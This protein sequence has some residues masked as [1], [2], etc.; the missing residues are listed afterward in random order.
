LRR[1]RE[2]AGID[3]H[4]V[5]AAELVGRERGLVLAAQ[6]HRR[7]GGDATER[8]ALRVDQEPLRSRRFDGR[9]LHLAAVATFLVVFLAAGA[10]ALAGADPAS[11]SIRS[12]SSAPS[13]LRAPAGFIDV[14]PDV[15]LAKR[16]RSISKSFLL[17]F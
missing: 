11:R 1:D 2:L 17:A 5:I 13:P 10:S 12:T 14:N 9:G 4:D 8:L 7:L 3:D 6:H 16:V 15:R